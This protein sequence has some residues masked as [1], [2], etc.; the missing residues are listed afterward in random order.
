MKENQRYFA[1]YK[2]DSLFNGFIVV[3]NSTSKDTSLIVKGNEK[4]LRARLSD[5]MFF[6]ENDLKRGLKAQGL[7]SVLF[8]EGLGT[9]AQKSL[10]ESKIA[11][12]LAQKFSTQLAQFTREF[13]TQ[14]TNYTNE[15]LL[16]LLRES[17]SLAKA[18]LLSEMVG[19]FPELQGIMGSYY[20][21][22][23]G[24]DILLVKALREQYF[25]NSEHSALP[26]NLFSAIVA[27]SYKL[28]NILSLFSINKIPSGSKDPYALR[29]AALGVI[30]IILL[31][32]LPFNLSSDLRDISHALGF[33]NLNNE[34]IADFFLERLESHLEL[35][36]SIFRAS[37]NGKSESGAFE[38]DILR[39]VANA[40]ALN[41]VFKESTDK[42]SLLS[43]FK[44]VAN[45]CKES[46]TQEFSTPQKEL[47]T[48]HEEHTLFE[49]LSQ[50]QNTQF[51]STKTRV[52]ALFG[53]KDI[54]ESFFDKVLIN[55]K[56]P[57]IATNRKALIFNVYREFLRVGDIAQIAI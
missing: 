28:D 52:S 11:Q 22:S 49:A 57:Q 36:P 43:T 55:D 54:L 25:P 35:N 32:K 39:L 10:R 46:S 1:L 40:N 37:V 45:I 47:F 14:N 44:R 33:E 26:S 30:K 17:I 56:N 8:V 7:E 24:K 27:L 12:V 5:A 29:R 53:L 21:Q 38:R 31:Y 48:L 13:A 51:E 6:Y 3:S 19:E 9:L 34:Q 23:E 16:E 18:D 4:V 50:I 15:R 42:P 41:S 20:A 2:E